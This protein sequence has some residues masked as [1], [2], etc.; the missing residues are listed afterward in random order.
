[1]D[2][3]KKELYTA[4]RSAGLTID[5]DETLASAIQRLKADADPTNW[6]LMK[7]VNNANLTLAS[8]GTGGASELVAALSDDDV[9]YGAIRCR[10]MDK[11]KFFHVY[12]VGAGVSA[13]KK[14]K[15]SLNKSAAFGAIDAH[16]EVSWP[17]GLDGF[18]VSQIQ[19]MLAQQLRC[20]A[21]QIDLS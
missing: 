4:K 6:L 3:T 7:I 5:G 21:E 15:A 16:G 9:Y 20:T 10:V 13:L 19:Q 14:G 8:C 18:T 2:P 17:S 1:M 11:V 12:F